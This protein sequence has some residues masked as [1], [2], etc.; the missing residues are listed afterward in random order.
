MM[1]VV[2]GLI[3]APALSKVKGGLHAQEGAG[4]L[5]RFSNLYRFELWR[6]KIDVDT[7][8]SSLNFFGKTKSTIWW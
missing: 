6:P 5:I 7:A 1:P 8:S 2:N 4:S 3:R